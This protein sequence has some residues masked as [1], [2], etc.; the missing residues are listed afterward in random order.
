MKQCPHCWE[1]I[2]NSAKKCR[3]CWEFLYEK[4]TNHIDTS[5]NKLSKLF[6]LEN[7]LLT[8]S[9]IILWIAVI[10]FWGYAYYIFVR[11]VIFIIMIVLFIKYYKF[12]S[13]EEKRLWLYWIT[14]FVYNPIFSIYLNKPLRT[15]IDIALIIIFIQIIRNNKGIINKE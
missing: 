11:L 2:Q 6:F 1:E 3:Y 8:I 12:K 14:A 7:K 5:E 13:Q 15:V 9:C 4:E 10:R